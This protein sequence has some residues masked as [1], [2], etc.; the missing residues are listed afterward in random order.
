MEEHRHSFTHSLK[1][2]KVSQSSQIKMLH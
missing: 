1:W 2:D